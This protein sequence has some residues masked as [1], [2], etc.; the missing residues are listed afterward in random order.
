M[1]K[2]VVQVRASDTKDKSTLEVSISADQ[3]FD[4][5]SGKSGQSESLN[6]YQPS[7]KESQQ[8]HIDSDESRSIKSVK[9][10]FDRLGMK[11]PKGIIFKE[12]KIEKETDQFKVPKTSDKANGRQQ[13]EKMPLTR[14]SSDIS[15]FLRGM[16]KKYKKKIKVPRNYSCEKCE[17]QSPDPQKYYKHVLYIHTGRQIQCDKCDKKYFS[18]SHLK[19]HIEGTHEAVMQICETCNFKTNK[20]RHLERHILDNHREGTILCSECPFKT[21]TNSKLKIH[22]E[23]SHTPREK[24]PKCPWPDCDYTWCHQQNVD[25]HYRKVH[26][27][28]RVSCEICTNTFTDK[29]NMQAHMMKIHSD[30]VVRKENARTSGSFEERYTVL[31]P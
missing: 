19:E 28:V 15:Y 6:S 30:L 18:M 8:K 9:D 22:M 5:D 20:K 21:S 12:E 3:P 29:S 27:G 2:F 11:M 13:Q 16:R 17:F 26:E 4:S 23:R 10:E 7:V 14:R 31:K 1:Y 25:N 24:W